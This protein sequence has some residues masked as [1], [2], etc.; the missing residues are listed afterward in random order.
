MRQD[1]ASIRPTS[2]TQCTHTAWECLPHTRD[3]LECWSV[4][5]VWVVSTPPGA[6]CCVIIS[7]LIHALIFVVRHQPTR[8]QSCH[9]L[10]HQLLTKFQFTKLKNFTFTSTQCMCKGSWWNGFSTSTC[11]TE[12]LLCAS[13]IF[14]SSYFRTVQKG[15]V[16]NS[17]WRRCQPNKGFKCLF[18][19]ILEMNSLIVQIHLER[20]WI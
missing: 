3:S 16:F 10:P 1:D 14:P 4:R 17:L 13:S 8:Q 12:H 19:N 5:W 7:L 9:I 15:G 11:S 18:K 2:R 6:P 20:D